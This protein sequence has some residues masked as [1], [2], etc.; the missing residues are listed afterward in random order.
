MSP[1]NQSR[2]CQNV[3][4][5]DRGYMI[6]RRIVLEA[7]TL[8][9]LGCSVLLVCTESPEKRYNTDEV[10]GVPIVRLPEYG[11]RELPDARLPMREWPSV[12][13]A[14]RNRQAAAAP[15]RPATTGPDSI[16]A[17]AP[18]VGL[19]NLRHRLAML[20]AWSRNPQVAIDRILALPGHRCFLRTGAVAIVAVLAMLRGFSQLPRA[21]LGQPPAAAPEPRA[22]PEC[23]PLLSENLTTYFAEHPLDAWEMQVARLALAICDLDAIHMHDVPALRPGIFAAVRRGLPAIFDAHELYAYQPNVLGKRKAATFESEAR[24]IHHCTRAVVINREQ[25]EVM[26]SD[27]RYERF[28]TLTNATERPAGFDPRR[29]YELIRERLAIRPEDRIMLFIGGI[30]TLRKIDQLM[31][32]MSRSRADVHLVLLTWGGEIPFFRNLARTLGIASRVHFLDPVPWSEIIYWC[33]SADVG[34]MPYQALDMNTR[35][36]SPNK[37]YEFIAAATP[38][39]GSSE[40]VNVRSIVEQEGFGLL[41]PLHSPKD[42]AALIDAVFDE[43]QGGPERFRPALIE[44]GDRY[45]WERESGDFIAMYRELLGLPDVLQLWEASA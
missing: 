43:S 41:R 22:Q 39:I 23:S 6:D 30:N 7:K 3:L 37:L 9:A 32:G 4:M 16:S 34:V 12:L 1:E 26:R 42:Y 21:F 25:A 2:G 5:I 28:V 35:I 31:E 27:Y 29:R 24:L 20:N 19:A 11:V 40:L 8:R 44:K 13:S 33:A 38:V 17:G 14:A 15:L 18:L 45:L 36:S 10:D